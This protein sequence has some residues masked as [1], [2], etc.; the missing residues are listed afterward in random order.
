VVASSTDPAY[1]MPAAAWAA[2]SGDPV[3]FAG[4]GAAPAPTLRELHRN[5][6]VPVYVLGP[7]SAVS[8]RALKLIAKVAPGAKRI[9]AAT[10]PVASS[11]AFARYSVAGFGWNINDPGH[12]F[13]VANA[14]RPL[15]AAAAAA[16]SASGTWGPLLVTTS[17]DSPPAALRNYL[18]D[19]KPGYRSDPTRAV[20]NHVWVIGDA[21]AI[22]VGFQA[23]LDDLAEAAQIGSFGQ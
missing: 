19:L 1:A 15:D 17:A 14:S 6:R 13:V 5:A 10:D 20:Y 12:G 21:S 16:L 8:D 23:E 7:P 2:R 11:V 18:L 22:S 3:L 9:A 4:R